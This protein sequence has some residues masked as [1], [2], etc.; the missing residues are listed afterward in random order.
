MKITKINLLYCDPVEDGWRP[1]FC[2]IYTDQGIYG[3]GEIALSY[4][5]VTQSAFTI[6][7]DFAGM[8]IG[9]DPLQHEVIWQKLYRQ[10]FFGLNGGP[11]TF[12][13]ISAFDVALWDIKG[14]AYNAPLHQLLGGKQRDTLRAYAS[15]L[16]NG[17]GVDRKPART[18]EDYARQAE[19]ARSLGFDA[20]KYNFLTFRPDEG[21]YA[22]TQQTAFLHPSYLNTAR[23]RIAAVR[24]VMGAEGDIILEN[25]CYTD[26]QSAVQYGN[27]AKE[28]DIL[29]YEEPTDP[30]SHLLSAVHRETGLPV[31]SGERMYGRWQFK[32][33]LDEQAIQV[34]QPD[35][36]TCGGITEAKK[37]CDLSYIY[38]AGVQIHVCGSPLIT[39]A[40]LHLE[41]VIPNFVLH[42]YNVNTAMPHMTALTKYNYEPVN[43][44][45][46]VPDLPG[47][48]NE[49]AD[50]TF[51]RSQVVT[52]Q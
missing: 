12:G 40:S 37:I 5:D 16:Q 19:V 39:A 24:Q 26:V 4:A 8:L 21:R 52:I 45:I 49:I 27:M 10:S 46:T 35:V 43:G 6:L 13:G 22:S 20:V 25:H 9:M 1:S 23:D 3:D 31:A 28:Y 47:I 29:Y 7:K 51:R 38:Q 15:Q 18:P 36:G 14:K 48:G 41:S 42:E 32:K 33:A 2:R 44:V 50:E 30:H 17:W 11:I 34:I